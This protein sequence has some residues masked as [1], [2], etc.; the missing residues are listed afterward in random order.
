MTRPLDDFTPGALAEARAIVGTD[1]AEAM[2][3]AAAVL[4]EYGLDRQGGSPH[5]WRCEYPDRYGPCDCACELAE[6]L[7]G[8]LLPIEETR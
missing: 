6:A 4:V 3:V 7:V 5:S 8:A 2:V 1:A